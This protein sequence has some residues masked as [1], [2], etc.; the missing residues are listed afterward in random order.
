L[1]LPEDAAAR[2]GALPS[3]QVP[4]DGALRGGAV[5]VVLPAPPPVRV[6]FYVALLLCSLAALLARWLARAVAADLQG[7]TRQIDRVT[8]EEEPE[9][10]PALSTAEV[11]TLAHA[12]N[13]LLERVPRFTVE[14]FLAIEHAQEA[15]RL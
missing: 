1:L 9:P 3:V 4:L 15:Q 12:V 11:Q 6:P 14:S 2:F 13:Q 8:G 5:R 7:L 10:L